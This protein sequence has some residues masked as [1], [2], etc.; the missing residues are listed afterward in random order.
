MAYLPSFLNA[1]DYVS[2]RRF[3][4][5]MATVPYVTPYTVD[6]TGVGLLTMNIG[7]ALTLTGANLYPGRAV[8]LRLVGTGTSQNL[9]FPTGWAFLG[10]AAPSA[11]AAGKVGV[12]STSAFG[13]SQSD[14]VAAWSVQP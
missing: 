7:G 1:T 12:L 14:I 11:L 13:T 6:F 3:E 8:A 9:T 4:T 10:S 5:Q 2:G